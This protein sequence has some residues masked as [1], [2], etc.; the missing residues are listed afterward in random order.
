M[1]DG[2]QASIIAH[3][4]KISGANVT[5][6]NLQACEVES[7][8]WSEPLSVNLNNGQNT[9]SAVS[10][11][12]EINAIRRNVTISSDVNMYLDGSTIIGEDLVDMN[13]LD[14]IWDPIWHLPVDTPQWLDGIDDP[15]IN[16]QSLDYVESYQN[17][18]T[19]QG[20]SPT[21][22]A[23]ILIAKYFTRRSG[24]SIQS[25]ELIQRMSH[26]LQPQI[27]DKEVINVLLSIGRS[28]LYSTFSIFTNFEVSK[29]TSLQLCLSMAAFGALFSTAE[30]SEAVSMSLYSDARH[31]Q[32]ETYIRDGFD[33]FTT[34]ANAAKTYL[35]LEI[36]G[37]CSGNKRM[38]EFCEA[39]H[40]NTIEAFKA[41][42]QTVP[43]EADEN[44]R[45]ELSQLVESAHLLDSFR[46]LLLSRPPCFLPWGHTTIKTDVSVLRPNVKTDLEALATP[47]APLSRSMATAQSLATLS[48]W[49][50]M[51][52]PRGQES[53]RG[54]QPWK[55]EF[56][57]LGLE[58]WK[59]ARTQCPSDTDFPLLLIYHLAYLNLYTNL[60]L[61]QRHAH[62]FLESSEIPG[63][64]KSIGAIRVWI[65]GSRAPVAH[66][67]AEA[68]IN[69][70][71]DSLG[72]FLPRQESMSEPSRASEPPHLPYCIYFAILVIWFYYVREGVH[73]VDM[74]NAQIDT[75]MLLLGKLRAPVAGV[76][77]VAL[78]NLREQGRQ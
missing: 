58:R 51:F 38:Y 76:I 48:S 13:F 74:R 63:D 47:T 39:F 61:L 57:E 2:H 68:M 45:A 64:V 9:G 73:M 49:T 77:S 30:G 35:L 34:A 32:M 41:C 46:V 53:T 27:Y 42:W 59:W 43:Q 62:E 5:C 11:Q 29:K 56:V 1:T 7:Q 71:K 40:Y 44:T 17:Q 4:A 24:Y 16:E 70:I 54:Y 75:A 55:T 6:V 23:V 18:H 60:P 31:L 25:R 36:Y 15:N 78:H 3:S 12:Q 10:S 8:A 33:S 66:W 26:T 72:I 14:P 67:H 28:H 20:A 65:N 21:E 22:T 69:L 19:S 50:W 37:I 52:S